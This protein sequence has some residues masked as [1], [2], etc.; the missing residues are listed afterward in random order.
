M[1]FSARL[2]IPLLA[3]VSYSALAQENKKESSGVRF[4]C[5]AIAPQTPEKLKLVGAKG[6]IDVTL[7]VRAP[8]DLFPLPADRSIVLGIPSN[9]PAHPVKALAIGK[10]PENVTSATALLIPIPT[11]PDGTRYHMLLISDNEAR[12]GDAYFINLLEQ[13]CAVSLDG[14][15]LMLKRGQ[16]QTFHPKDLQD[17][18]NV[19]IAVSVEQPDADES[20]RWKL[21]TAST[22][23][24]RKSRIELCVIYWDTAYDRPALKGITLYPDPAKTE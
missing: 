24:L 5:S 16:P 20:S 3:L 18:K 23:R 21:L 15:K 1:I 8:G 10:L 9:D 11:K 6:V 17:G 19:T 4:V 2:A 7:G 14:E 12:G 13:R 22:W